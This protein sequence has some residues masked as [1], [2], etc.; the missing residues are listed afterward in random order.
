MFSW[1]QRVHTPITTQTRR[2]AER[3]PFHMKTDKIPQKEHSC[4]ISGYRTE[5]ILIGPLAEFYFNISYAGHYVCKKSFSICRSGLHSIILLLITAGEGKLLYQ[6]KQ[7]RLLP[8]S[9]VLIDS[10]IHHAYHAA[11]DG[12]TFKYLQF[13]GG[14]SERCY[15][16]TAANLGPVFQI[17]PTVALEVEEHLDAI[18]QETEKTHHI[19]YAIVSSHIYSILTQFLSHNNADYHSE[20]SSVGLELALAYI[21]NHYHKKISTDDIAAAAYL[22][23]SYLSELFKKK[24]GSGPH[25]YLTMY[26]LSQVKKQLLNTNCSIAEIADQT[27]F[28]D[29]FTLSRVFKRKFGITPTEYRKQLQDHERN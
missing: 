8:N 19:D 23:R 14:M 12:W 17:S 25:E 27:G 11:E 3:N 2:T 6:G 24:Y 7:Y 26:R 15:A 18:M 29:I 4:L 9:V 21:T 28:R 16:Y 13:Q 20:K 10:R 22:S 5:D 1:F